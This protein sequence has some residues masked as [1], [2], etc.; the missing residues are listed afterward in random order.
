M[1]R[2]SR[3]IEQEGGPWTCQRYIISG[4]TEAGNADINEEKLH[5]VAGELDAWNMLFTLLQLQNV[6]V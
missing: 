3:I 1:W 6:L 5:D 2:Y 4:I